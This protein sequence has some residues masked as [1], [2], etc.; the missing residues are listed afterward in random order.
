MPAALFQRI[1][2]TVEP[3]ADRPTTYSDP[4]IDSIVDWTSATMQSWAT[5]LKTYAQDRLEGVV[6]DDIPWSK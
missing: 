4:S 6:S 3:S 2:S 1:H 5:G